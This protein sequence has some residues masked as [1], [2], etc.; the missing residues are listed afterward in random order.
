MTGHPAAAKRKHRML[1]IW[2]NARPAFT[3]VANFLVH[4]GE[5]RYLWLQ[6]IPTFVGMARRRNSS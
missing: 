6:S 3:D 2:R 5:G 4:T 1:K